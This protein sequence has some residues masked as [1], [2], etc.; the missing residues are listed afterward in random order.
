MDNFRVGYEEENAQRLIGNVRYHLDALG[1]ELISLDAFMNGFYSRENTS[2]IVRG[3][4]NNMKSLLCVCNYM[5]TFSFPKKPLP[6]N[7]EKTETH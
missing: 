4:V 3:E 6:T 5:G 1:K 2:H 7:P